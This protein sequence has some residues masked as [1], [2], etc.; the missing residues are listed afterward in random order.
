MGT[1]TG[2]RGE[3]AGFGGLGRSG[4]VLGEFRDGKWPRCGRGVELLQAARH[5][6]RMHALVVPVNLRA[7]SEPSTSRRRR[8]MPRHPKPRPSTT[9]LMLLLWEGTRRER[10][11]NNPIRSETPLTRG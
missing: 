5:S 10:E 2:P 6:Y 9:G 7:A 1:R 8:A 11:L 4:F 3:S